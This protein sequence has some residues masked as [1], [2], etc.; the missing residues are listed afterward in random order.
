[1]SVASTPGEMQGVFPI[2]IGSPPTFPL[3]MQGQRLLD[4]L[5][6]YEDALLDDGIH[7]GRAKLA[8]GPKYSRDGLGCTPCG[9]CMHGCPNQ[10]IFNAAFVLD[11]LRSRPGIRYRSNVLAESFS[12]A[13][14]RVDI[15]VKELGSGNRTTLRFAR[16]FL[17]CGVVNSTAIVAR[18]LGMTEHDFTI[19]DSQ[20][21][22]FPM[23]LWRRSKGAMEHRDNTLAQIYLAV[24]NSDVSDRIVQVQYYGYNDLLLDPLRSRLGQRATGAIAR[25][26]APILER[27]VIGFVYLHSR[28]S[29]T[30][31]LRV[32]DFDAKNGSLGEIRGQPN[33]RSASVVRALLALLKRH[34]RAH[35]GVPLPVGLLTMRP[36]DSQHIGSTLPMAATPG[37]Y[38]T[39]LLG[40]PLSCKRVHVVDASV[41]PTIPG[42][43]IVF[44]AMANASRIA[45]GAVRESGCA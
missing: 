21:Y 25:L 39:D 34:R 33:P 18:S 37:R 7:V 35:G 23:L 15:R 36:G 27:L 42:T 26:A 44:T 6:K 41:L 11:D 45:A 5:K 40:R 14:D 10:A 43:P 9:L 20:K 13:G 16:V 19:K 22:I 31:S 17:A 3:G 38:E 4:R 12:E 8:V 32:H 1:M 30:L 29:G 28:D 24:D 2:E